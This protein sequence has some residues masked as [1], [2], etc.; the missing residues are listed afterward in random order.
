[1]EERK[2]FR[3]TAIG[4]FYILKF[5]LFSFYSNF[6]INAFVYSSDPTR[7][8]DEHQ[9]HTAYFNGGAYGAAHRCWDTKKNKNAF[10]FCICNQ[11]IRKVRIVASAR[12]YWCRI[13]SVAVGT[14]KA[15]CSIPPVCGYM[16][17]PC[18]SR[19]TS[20][21]Y[22]WRFFSICKDEKLKNSTVWKEACNG[23]LGRLGN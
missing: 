16:H 12:Y 1:M 21:N 14:R 22:S 7:N 9:A 18:W 10:N 11:D 13:A 15:V 4:I 5:S 17:L 8:C 23:P 2:K 3:N 6:T 19:G 20:R